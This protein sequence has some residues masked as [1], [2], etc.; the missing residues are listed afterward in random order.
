MYNMNIRHCVL[1]SSI[2]PYTKRMKVNLVAS[3][4]QVEALGALLLTRAFILIFQNSFKTP[5]K[6]AQGRGHEDVDCIHQHVGVLKVVLGKLAQSERI[7]MNGLCLIVPHVPGDHLQANRS[8]QSDSCLMALTMSTPDS[9]WSRTKSK[10]L[11][12]SSSLRPS[13]RLPLFRPKEVMPLGKRPV[14]NR[15]VAKTKATRGK[16]SKASKTRSP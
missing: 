13:T 4:S 12:T 16:K 8:V 6:V 3:A 11:A 1:Y 9:S 7:H 2:N 5:G 14:N 10:S 15:P